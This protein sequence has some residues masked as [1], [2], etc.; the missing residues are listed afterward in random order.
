MPFHKTPYKSGN[1]FIHFT[2]KF[3]ESLPESA[4]SE[5]QEVL[6]FLDKKTAQQKKDLTNVPDIIQ[7]TKFS[8][9][10]ENTHA[11]GGTKEDH[12]ED[13]DDDS[14][15]GGGPRGAQCQAQ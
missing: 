15:E 7:L 5:V 3:P 13:G 11:A 2:V 12:R 6:G 10:Q 14:D 1:L 4:M 8:K 9:S